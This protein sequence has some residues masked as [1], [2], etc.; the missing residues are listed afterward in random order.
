MAS[1]AADKILTAVSRLG[2]GLGVAAMVPSLCLFD[3]DGGQ[4]VVVLNMFS[5][6]E[7]KVRG[8]GTHFK[9]PWVMQPKIYNVRT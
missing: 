2:L 8:E 4:R 3:V 5:G 9:I 6:V 1:P 7:D